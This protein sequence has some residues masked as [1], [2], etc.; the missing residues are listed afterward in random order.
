MIL[1]ITDGKK[2]SEIKDF[3]SYTSFTAGAQRLLERKNMNTVL[4]PDTLFVFLYMQFK[5]YW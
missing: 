4:R 3:A 2:S 5:T 1:V